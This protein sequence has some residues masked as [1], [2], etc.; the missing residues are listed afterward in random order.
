[1]KLAKILHIEM[2][3]LLSR[4]GPPLIQIKQPKLY[5]YQIL[6]CDLFQKDKT[7]FNIWV[8]KGPLLC[9]VLVLKKYNN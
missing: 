9:L 8:T 7:S 3:V 2:F 6:I 4:H 5:I 1:M